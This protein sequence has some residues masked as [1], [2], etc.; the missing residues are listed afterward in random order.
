M[1]LKVIASRCVYCDDDLDGQGSSMDRKDNNLGYLPDNVVPCCV[2]CNKAKLDQFTYDEMLL[3][4]EAIRLVK[5]KRR[6]LEESGAP[7]QGVSP[8]ESTSPPPASPDPLSR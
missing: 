5:Q 7:Y 8:H 1:F 6:V 2:G 3:I 4:G